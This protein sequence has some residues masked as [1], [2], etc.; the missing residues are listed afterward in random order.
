MAF[1][2]LGWFSSAIHLLDRHN[3]TVSAAA[4]AAICVLTA[5]LLWTTKQQ[6]RLTRDAVNLARAEFT[7]AHPPKLVLLDTVMEAE[8]VV[9]YTLANVG[10]SPATIQESWLQAEYLNPYLPTRSSRSAGHDDLGRLVFAAGEIK[11]LTY[12]LDREISRYL[13]FPDGG[14][15]NPDTV[16]CHPNNLHFS[17]AIRFADNEGVLRRTVFRR[18]WSHVLRRFG[19]SSEPENEYAE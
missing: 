10:G 1:D 18:Q 14:R 8:W 17:G 9:A 2:N 7:A 3:G 15:L 11:D 19:P 4:T 13:D 5:G 12:P 6:A 16:H